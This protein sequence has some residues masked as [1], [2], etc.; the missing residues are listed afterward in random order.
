[1][2]SA[3][4]IGMAV[5]LILFVW[6]WIMVSMLQRM[7]LEKKIEKL[8]NITNPLP[9]EEKTLN[10]YKELRAIEQSKVSSA[11]WVIVMFMLAIIGCAVATVVW[12][13]LREFFGYP[14]LAQ[15]LGVCVVLLA[16]FCLPI[17]MG[18]TLAGGSTKEQE[19]KEEVAAAD[20]FDD[21]PLGADAEAEQA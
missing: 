9:E 13:P 10:H 21:R 5:L 12:E 15:F 2:N 6:S 11:R 1:M 4:L 7:S 20:D 18:L 8:N 14:P 16:F 3:I 19:R 17:F